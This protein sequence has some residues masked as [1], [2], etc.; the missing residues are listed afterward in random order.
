MFSPTQ[1]L[2]AQRECVLSAYRAAESENRLRY[3]K[4]DDKA[5]SEYIY[6]NQIEDAHLIV[7]HFYTSN[8]RVVSVQ[9]K[10][11]VGADGLMIEVAKLMTT[12]IVD[13]RRNKTPPGFLI[14]VD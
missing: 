10:T 7:D 12:H 9:K 13:A 3:M 14:I 4:G 8:R 1:K 2:N 11:K 5:T 6:P